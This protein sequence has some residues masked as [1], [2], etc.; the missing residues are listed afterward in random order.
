ML[1]ELS[2]ILRQNHL[3]VGIYFLHHPTR[4]SQDHFLHIMSL[5][6]NFKCLLICI[7]L[8]SLQ[9][10]CANDLHCIHLELQFIVMFS[11]TICHKHLLPKL[12][13]RDIF[14]LH[15]TSGVHHIRLIFSYLNYT[16]NASW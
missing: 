15:C 11:Y 6:S 9:F 1:I 14:D 3:A 7:C 2:V 5:W 4:A 8:M 13:G 10:F 12:V 16:I